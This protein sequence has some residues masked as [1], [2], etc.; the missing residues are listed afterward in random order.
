MQ[1][2]VLNVHF[3]CFWLY[4]LFLSKVLFKN[5]GDHCALLSPMPSLA[6]QIFNERDC[7]E[8]VGKFLRHGRAGGHAGSR[9][10]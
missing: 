4:C 1:L 7:V 2:C 8:S 10:S 5:L 9:G 3:F 6:W